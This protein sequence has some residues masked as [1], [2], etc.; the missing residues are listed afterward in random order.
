MRR[1]RRCNKQLGEGGLGQ[2]GGRNGDRKE[3]A[4]FVRHLR[5]E[6]REEDEYKDEEEE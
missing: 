2:R 3:V 5:M 4:V 1:N 6:K